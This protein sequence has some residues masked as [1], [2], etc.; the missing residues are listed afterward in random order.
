[1]WVLESYFLL[2]LIVS[3]CQKL[4]DVL[5]SFSIKTKSQATLVKLVTHAI[6][7]QLVVNLMALPEKVHTAADIIGSGRGKRLLPA[8]KVLTNRVKG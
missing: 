5:E 8:I 3:L 1:M 7:F 2:F 6:N 4:S